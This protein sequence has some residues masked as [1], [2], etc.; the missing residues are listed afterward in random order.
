[1]VPSGEAY[2]LP[3]HVLPWRD[4]PLGSSKAVTYLPSASAMQ[5]G[6]LEPRQKRVP[7]VLAIGNPANMSYQDVGQPT[8]QTFSPLPAAEMEAVYVASLFPDG[9]ALIGAD[10][11]EASVRAEISSYSILHFATHGHLSATAPLQSAVLLAN[12]GALTVYDLME[13]HIDA[14]L[15]VLSACRTGQGETTR[16]DDVLGLTRALLATGAGAVVVSL[17]Q[18]DDLATSVLMGE[19][20]R[21]L[22]TGKPPMT[23][24]MKAQT[25][26][27]TRTYVD[28]KAELERL[29]RLAR[30]TPTAG[31]TFGRAIRNMGGRNL[32]VDNLLDAS[33]LAY[34]HPHFWAAFVLIRGRCGN[35]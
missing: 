25:Y 26:L 21:Q 20:Y 2:L 16:G 32:A 24:L 15:V 18:V 29:R 17:W 22:S 14:D 4:Q 31:D 30:D 28:A 35:R 33:E 11:N 12:G 8:A 27:R 10:A 19:F 9:K 13:L 5:F 3:F 34:D 7:S 6:R 1:M 23:A